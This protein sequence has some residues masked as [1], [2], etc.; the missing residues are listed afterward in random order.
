MGFLKTALTSSVLLAGHAIAADLP[1]IKMKG[2]KF[3]FENGTQFFMKGV[4]YQQETGAAGETTTNKY[5]DPLSDEAICERDVPLLAALGTNTIRTY[6]ID[7]TADHSACMALLQE[8]G[9]YVVSDLSEPA[10]SINRDDPKW[11][12]ELFARYK[13]VVDEMSKY[14]NVIGFFAGNEVTNSKNNTEASAYVKAAVRDTKA[15]IAD[16]INRWMGVGYAANDDDAIR[17]HIAQYFNCGEE[18]DSIDF[19]GYNIY[20]WCG[21]ESSMSISGY[22]KQVEFFQNYSVPV[23]FAEYGCNTGGAESRVWDDTTALYSDEM[24]DVFSGGIVYMYFQEDNDYG[25]VSISNDEAST[26]DNYKALKTKLASVSPSS[27]AY[28]SYSPTNSAQACP[29]IVD[30]W[31]ASENLPPTPDSE[32]CECMFNSISCGPASDL[33]TDDY[34]DIFAYICEND[35]EG[36]TGINGNATTGVYGPYVMCNDT[37]KLGYVLDHYYKSLDQASDACDFEGQAVVNS[38]V[39]SDSAC[40][41]KLASASSAAEVAATATSPSTS[42]STGTGSSS[43][44]S[45]NPANN[46]RMNRLF[47]LG[48]LA[49]GAYLLVAMGVGAGMVLL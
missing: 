49:I 22:D 45:G 19:W 27:T 17:A 16:N 21:S 41:D 24:T 18:S 11:D 5:I 40:S 48:D 7:P 33:S 23:F 1:S 38:D 15:Y 46:L 9:I 42:N 14:S 35:A 3:F 25:I 28:D 12:T 44:E 34:G 20:S 4:A 26:M 29:S 47:A 37:Q 32:L 6:A 39:A 8:N 13:S 36:C 30:T 31:K 2:S 10:L 43:S